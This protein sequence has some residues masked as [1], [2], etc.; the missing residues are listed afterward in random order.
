LIHFELSIRLAL[1]KISLIATSLAN[2]EFASSD[3]KNMPNRTSSK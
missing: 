2:L 1:G 3:S